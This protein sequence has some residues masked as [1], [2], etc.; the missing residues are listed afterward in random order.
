[1]QCSRQMA[2]GL[3]ACAADAGPM[4]LETRFGGPGLAYS[5]VSSAHRA[6]V[7]VRPQPARNSDPSEGRLPAG[8]AALAN[9]TNQPQ[10]LH[11]NHR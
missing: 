2:C 4:G 1:M 8:D 10:V 5:A 9:D 7:R 3:A 11:T 6:A